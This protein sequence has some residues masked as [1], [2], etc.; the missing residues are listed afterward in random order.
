M[1]LDNFLTDLGE[2]MITES[3]NGLRGRLRVNL[4][5][6]KTI[7]TRSAAFAKRLDISILLEG[8]RAG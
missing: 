1:N 2:T 7:I 5:H 6:A 4:E 8:L 3:R